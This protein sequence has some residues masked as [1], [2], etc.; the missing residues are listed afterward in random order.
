[1][2]FVDL[3]IVLDTILHKY[4]LP[5]GA[6]KARHSCPNSRMMRKTTGDSD[7]TSEVGDQGEFIGGSWKGPTVSYSSNV[8]T[9][10]VRDFSQLDIHHAILTTCC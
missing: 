2:K 10:K 4:L 5:P 9:D 7:C 6:C 8:G 1:M 3:R